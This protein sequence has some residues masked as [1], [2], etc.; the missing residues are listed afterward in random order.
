MDLS[1][2]L[3]NWNSVAYLRECIASIYR[4]TSGL[5]FEVIVVDNASPEGGIDVLQEEFPQITILKSDT[6]IGFA[7]AN[8][9]GFSHSS[10]NHVLLLNPD[11][12]LVNPAIN[13][14]MECMKSLPDAGI[15]GCKLLNTDLSVQTASVQKFPTLL[16]QLLNIE[17]L[18]VHWPGCPL[19][20]IGPL[21]RQSAKPV[22]VEVIPG[23]C[24]LMKRE[25]FEKAGLYTE[26]YFMYAEVIDLNYKMRQLGLSSYYVGDAQIVH[27][28]GTSSSCQ[29]ISHWSLVM[30][31][32]AMAKF[33]RMRGGW[34]YS[35]FYRATMAVSAF[36]HIVL[37]ALSFPFRDKT[38]TKLTLSKWAT[39]LKWSAG[40]DPLKGK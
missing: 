29:A 5:S 12:R 11:T 20:D 2:I 17:F 9:L 4:Y 15:V 6:N 31:H 36:L 27:H 34:I 28:G 32:R 39:V 16:N 40:W 1:I 3:V 21:Y 22:K 25:A 23:A 7:A 24:M 10:G 19:W 37:L 33:Y 26:D 18:R 35:F 13:I 38:S 30:K 14:L 8:N